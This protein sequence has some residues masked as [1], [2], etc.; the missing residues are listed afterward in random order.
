[1]E[2]GGNFSSTGVNTGSNYG[3]KASAQYGGVNFGV[4]SVVNSGAGT[5]PWPSDIA[6][7]G[8]ADSVINRTFAGYFD[9]NVY[10]NGP[11]CGNAYALTSDAIFKS[12]IDSIH[13]ATNLIKQLKP[14][15]YDMVQNNP[16]GM[17]FPREHQMGF[18]AQ[19]LMTVLPQIVIQEHKPAMVDTSGNIVTQAIDYKAVNYFG[20]IPL[21]CRGF[22]E[23]SKIIDSSNTA[24]KKAIDSLKATNTSLQNQINTLTNL[25]NSCCNANNNH[26]PINN[27]G[28]GNGNNNDK[29]NTSFIDVTLQDGQSIVLSSLSQNDPNP[30]S[31]N[32]TIN[33]FLTE[34]VQ[35]AEMLFYNAGGKLIQ[36]VELNQR[37]NG[38]I[39]VYAADLSKGMYSYTL[40]IDGKIFATKKMV[41]Q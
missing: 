12:N 38:A 2:F 13:N 23:Q 34:D 35:K 27:N 28:N 30:Y 16:Y 29:S 6:I 1:M 26:A 17:K 24:S 39:S 37:G 11:T 8:S 36:S 4:F 19:D 9:G 32:T 21:L 5:F 10:I 7:Y 3:I 18:I 22:Q 33:F 20:I 31:E 15:T 40:V 41:K 25:I 14:K